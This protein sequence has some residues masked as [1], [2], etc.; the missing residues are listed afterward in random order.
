MEATYHLGGG[1]LSMATKLNDWLIRFVWVAQIMFVVIVVGVIASAMDR[2]PPFSIQEHPLIEARAVELVSV[3]VPVTR[4][5]SRHCD[6]EIDRYLFDSAG[7]RFDLA[8]GLFASD[9]MIRQIE[10]KTPGRLRFSL[11]LPPAATAENPA[12]IA[13]GDARFVNEL[14]YVCSKGHRFW[15]INVHTEIVIR[16]LP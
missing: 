7:A 6:A 14:R 10:E 8:S 12:G 13:P 5:L 11:Q 16:V 3:D 9:A 4:D 1:A 2:K 15:P